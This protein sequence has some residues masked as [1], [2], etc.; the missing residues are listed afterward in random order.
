MANVRKGLGKRKR[1]RE[2]VKSWLEPWFNSFSWL[3]TLLPT[4]LAPYLWLFH[5]KL[6]SPVYEIKTLDC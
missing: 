6:I 3:T 4:L 1:E 2:Q 5:F